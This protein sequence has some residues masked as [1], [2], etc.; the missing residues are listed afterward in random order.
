MREDQQL[1]NMSERFNKE[2]H[3]LPKEITWK[4]Q[5]MHDCI[6]NLAKPIS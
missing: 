5:Y 1:D 6:Y 3:K 4:L 2:K